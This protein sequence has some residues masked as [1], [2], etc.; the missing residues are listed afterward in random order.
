MANL[1]K[2]GIDGLVTI[3]GD[4]TQTIA[5]NF[6]QRGMRVVGVPKT[7]DNDLESTDVTFG[8]DTALNI[9]TD[10]ID[11]LHTTAESHDRVM[12]LEVMGRTAGWIALHAG[13]A[14]GADVILIPEIPFEIERVAEAIKTRES[15]GHK[16]SIVVVAEGAAPKGGSA[17]MAEAS[18]VGAAA[19]FGGIGYQVGAAIR[20]LTGKDTRV[21]VLGHLQRGGQPTAFD[22]LLGTS[23]GAAAI[24]A[25]ADGNSGVLVSMRGFGLT[26]VSLEEVGGRVKRIPADLPLLRVARAVGIELGAE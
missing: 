17:V 13:I 20:E 12:I 21:V 2:H 1:L 8:F 6:V 22:R 19:R 23:L 15:T 7:I 4:G 24:H 18:V 9:A 5:C 10:A 16:F 26:T 14:G 25:L 3:G 11:R